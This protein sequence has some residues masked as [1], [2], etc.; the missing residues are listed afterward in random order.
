VSTENGKVTLTGK[1]PN[2]KTIER[3]I[4]KANEAKGVVEVISKIEVGNPSSVK[5]LV[6][7]STITTIIKLSLL[8][9]EHLSSLD[10]NIETTNGNVTLAGVVPDEASNQRVISIVEAINGVKTV[11]SKIKVDK[12]SSMKNLISDSIITSTIKLRLLEDEYLNGLDIHVKTI[13]GKVTLSGV[14][15]DEFSSKRAISITKLINGVTEV[16]SELDIKK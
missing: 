9:D 5:N 6:S 13:N 2:K 12:A 15:P 10:I 11:S 16:I 14:V 3:I 8:E 4:A 1:A 7:D